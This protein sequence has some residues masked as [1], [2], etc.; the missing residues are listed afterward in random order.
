M[1]LSKLQSNANRHATDFYS[2]D[3]PIKTPDEDD[4]P[5]QVKD[6]QRINEFDLAA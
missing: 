4:R 2:H 3:R 1:L 5:I 6:A